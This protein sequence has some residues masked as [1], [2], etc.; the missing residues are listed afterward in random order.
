MNRKEFCK[1]HWEYHLVLE[2]DF[3]QSERYISFDLGDNYLYDNMEHSDN[4]NSLT[5]SNEYIKL[6][7][8][9]CSE[10]DVI[11]KSICKELGNL[12]ANRMDV[13][14]TPTILVEWPNIP[15]QKVR[16]R[17]IEL[18]PLSNWMNTPYQSPDW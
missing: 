5:F 1:Y 10:V 2:K 7:Q 13:G 9:I 3:L 15:M 4:G 18:V 14:Y 8:A 11:L 17:D 12:N 6:Y 16:F